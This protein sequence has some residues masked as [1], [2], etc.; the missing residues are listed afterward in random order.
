LLL[1]ILGIAFDIPCVL[2]IIYDTCPLRAKF[3]GSIVILKF[4]MM[5]RR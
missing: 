1:H 4:G 3:L 5:L 2:G